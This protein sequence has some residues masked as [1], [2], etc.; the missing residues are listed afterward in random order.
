MDEDARKST[1][2]RAARDAEN[3]SV[4]RVAIIDDDYWAL[5]GQ[6]ARLD[7][8]PQIMVIGTVAHPE[9][10][11]WTSEWDDVD[12]RITEVAADTDTARVGLNVALPQENKPEAS[13][14]Q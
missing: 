7:G 13:N 10:A 11:A 4:R 12:E 8:H 6:R 2:N 14:D 3:L 5:E 1:L 9:A